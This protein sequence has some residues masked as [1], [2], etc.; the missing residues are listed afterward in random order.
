MNAGVSPAI[1]SRSG[2]HHCHRN[3]KDRRT[4]ESAKTSS[5][6]EMWALWGRKKS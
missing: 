5:R 6:S 1:I 2:L 3:C 4:R